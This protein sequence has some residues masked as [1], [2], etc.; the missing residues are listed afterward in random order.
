MPTK[1]WVAPGG[2]L[3]PFQISWCIDVEATSYLEAIDK[4]VELMFG[5][6]TDPQNT[7]TYFGYRDHEHDTGGEID[8]Y[9]HFFPRTEVANDTD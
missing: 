9:D 8:A 7:A 2:D 1:K 5:V 3:R 6:G 4:A